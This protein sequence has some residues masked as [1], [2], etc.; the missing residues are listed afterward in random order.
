MICKST[1]Q[2]DSGFS[3][4]VCRR[5]EDGKH[6]IR[7]NDEDDFEV[8]EIVETDD[9]TPAMLEAIACAAV[10]GYLR[11]R[12]DG[13]HQMQDVVTRAAQNAWRE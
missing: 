3:A 12:D 2:F 13:R 8:M 6:A 5:A 4:H 11:G 9:I 7:I 10:H 1:Y